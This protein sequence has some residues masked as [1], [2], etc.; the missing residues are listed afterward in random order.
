MST[1]SLKLYNFSFLPT[2]K[3]ISHLSSRGVGETE[4]S[5]EARYGR[6]RTQGIINV[7]SP[8]MGGFDNEFI[9]HLIYLLSKKKKK[10]KRN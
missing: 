8:D 6:Y 10:K 4:I 3:V 7:I 2:M 5:P 9:I 1:F